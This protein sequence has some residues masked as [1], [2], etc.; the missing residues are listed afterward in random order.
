MARTAR[1]I[2]ADTGAPW[3]WPVHLL[4]AWCAMAQGLLRPRSE[5][6][7]GLAGL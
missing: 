7:R 6:A 5:G 3:P 4:P 2:G 1:E